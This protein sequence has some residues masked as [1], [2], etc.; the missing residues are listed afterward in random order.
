LK[1]TRA[2]LKAKAREVAEQLI[3][4]EPLTMSPTVGLKEIGRMFGAAGHT[5][6]QW[7]NRGVLPE[8]D[9]PLSGNPAWRLP[10]IYQFAEDTG[11]TIVWDP[12]GLYA[13]SG[14]AEGGSGVAAVED[15]D[16]VPVEAAS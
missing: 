8:A 15:S 3:G 9:A 12:W 14:E 4:D 10:T 5:P 11:R 2:Q 7:K 16:E 6:Y 13:P 1:V